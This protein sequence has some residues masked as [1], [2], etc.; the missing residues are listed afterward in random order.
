M[1]LIAIGMAFVEKPG[2][3]PLTRSAAMGRSSPWWLA[4]AVSAAVLLALVGPAYAYR[5]DNLFPAAQLPR[6]DSPHVSSSWHSLS[7]TLPNWR[8]VVHGADREF[9]EEFEQPGSGIVVRYLALYRCV[10]LGTC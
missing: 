6:G 2:R 10:R 8:P 4:V 5:L 9:L 3:P 1:V 7:G